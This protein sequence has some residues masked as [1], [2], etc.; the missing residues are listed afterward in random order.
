MKQNNK[1]THVN[2]V[3]NNGGSEN[4]HNTKY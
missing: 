4:I 3:N 2:G 1:Y